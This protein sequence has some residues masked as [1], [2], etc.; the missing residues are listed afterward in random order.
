M[1]GAKPDDKDTSGDPRI[2]SPDDDQTPTKVILLVTD[3]EDPK[4][5]E[6]SLLDHPEKAERMVETLLEAG[7]EQERIRAFMGV[8]A[9]IVVTHRPVATLVTD[10]ADRARAEPA[11]ADRGNG[12]EERGR[13]SG[14]LPSNADTI[15]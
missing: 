4:H 12:R 1:S 2:D 10:G 9:T 8:E 15:A 3:P 11:G 13:L 7:F 6:V 14:H 5:G